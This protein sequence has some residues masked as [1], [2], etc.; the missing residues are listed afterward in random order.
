MKVIMEFNR[1][2]RKE[3]AFFPREEEDVKER[4]KEKQTLSKV[5]K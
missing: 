2:Q 4:F 3:M 5:L 1:A